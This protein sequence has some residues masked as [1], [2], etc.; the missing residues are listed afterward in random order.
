MSNE[1]RKTK[2]VPFKSN[3]D[4]IFAGKS[5]IGA[6]QDASEQGVQY[7]LTSL[8]DVS[9]DFV[10]E[11]KTELVLKDPSGKKYKLKCEVKWYLRGKGSD[12]SITMGMRISDPPSKYRELIASL[13]ESKDK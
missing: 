11:S 2:R 7:L 4:I 3:A 1:R 6:V 10:P 5:Y 9:S 13:T 12:N 8:P